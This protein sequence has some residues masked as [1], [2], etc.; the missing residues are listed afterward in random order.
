VGIHEMTVTGKALTQAL[1][2]VPPRY[3]F[4]TG[5]PT[6]GRQGL[7]RLQGLME[8]QRHLEEYNGIVSGAPAINWTRF[9]PQELWGAVVM[10]AAR[11]SLPACE[12][13]AASAAAMLSWVEGAKCRRP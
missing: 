2:G 3:S 7:Q 6:G 1:Y 5:A 11:D 10:N 8:S 4:S 9:I 12:L 13:A